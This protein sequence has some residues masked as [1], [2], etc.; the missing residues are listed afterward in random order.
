MD[1]L[2]EFISRNINVLDLDN[3]LILGRESSRNMDYM[4][5]SYG[6]EV[7][8]SW[9]NNPQKKASK[10]PPK[11]TG[12]KPSYIKLMVDG[13][14]QHNELS[15]EAAGFLLKL[16][17]NIQW[18]T[19]L[20]INK[21]NKKPLAVDEITGIIG[22]GRNKTLDIVKELTQAQLLSKD[23]DGYKISSSLIQKGGA[24]K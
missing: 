24:A 1:K 17:D 11:H 19:N 6:D 20:L 18:S 3:G 23:K 4:T 10:N 15:I 9:W 16:T 5:I 14:R 22:V 8:F 21:R 2:H 12:G 13:V 7:L